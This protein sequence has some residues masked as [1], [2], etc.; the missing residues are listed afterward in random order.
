MA[1]YGLQM[2][3]AAG[4][5]VMSSSQNHFTLAFQE[6][7]GDGS[8]QFPVYENTTIEAHVVPIGT[9]DGQPVYYMITN[10]T[11]NGGTVSWSG[12]S[13]FRS[14]CAVLVIRRGVN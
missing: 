14:G 8:M 12:V 6:V 11:V 4:Q 10:L 5:E 9:G 7:A 3:N 13:G 1:T 2:F